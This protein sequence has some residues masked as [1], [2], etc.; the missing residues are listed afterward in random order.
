LG[1][2]IRLYGTITSSANTSH[3]FQD[4]PIF[5]SHFSNYFSFETLLSSPDFRTQNLLLK[6]NFSQTVS[7][8]FLFVARGTNGEM[9]KLEAVL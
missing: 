1:I 2:L 5:I 6:A 7:E 9:I 4:K 3:F 8:N